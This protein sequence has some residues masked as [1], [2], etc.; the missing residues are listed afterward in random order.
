MIY[1]FNAAEIDGNFLK[2]V[3]TLFAGEEVEITVKTVKPK[4]ADTSANKKI[5]LEMIEENRRSAPVIS[6][7][8]DIRALI[9]GSQ[10]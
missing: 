6:P 7:N 10:Y 1:R 2:S 3:E 5:L 4:H 8:V 9:D